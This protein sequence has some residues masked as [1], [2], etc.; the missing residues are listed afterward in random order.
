VTADRAA[1]GP[2]PTVSSRT[3]VPRLSSG[4]LVR[5]RDL[6][7]PGTRWPWAGVLLLAIVVSGVEA[8]G[9]VL[10]YTLMGLASDPTGAVDLPL[11]GDL[12][13]AFAETSTADLVAGVAVA[14]SVFFVVR[15]GLVVAQTYA[16]ARVAAA[17]SVWLST[18]LLDRYL[19]LPYSYHLRRN[20]SELIRNAN[21]SVTVVLEHILLP[22]VRIV[23]QGS[24][25]V[26]LC[27]VLISTAPVATLASAALLGPTTYLTMRWVRRRLLEYGSISQRERGRGLQL[28]QQSLHGF[29]D[30]TVLGRQAFFVD[31]FR[32]TRETIARTRY[33]RAVFGNLPRVLIE[34]VT[35]CLVAAAVAVTTVTN[36]GSGSLAVVGLF[37]YAALRIMP[38]L[39]EIT[40]HLNDVRYGRAALD[41]VH[42]DL[43]E[44]T[45]LEA[46]SGGTLTFR[47]E[48]RFESVTF[49]Y[50]G[51]ATPTLIGIDL[52]LPR[53]SSLGIVG[54]TGAGK[55]TL[56]DLLTGFL[57]PDD[58]V[59]LVDG[60]ALTGHE[61]AWRRFVG[62]VPQQVFLLDGTLRDNIAFGLPR[63]V[64]DDERV[65]SAVTAAQLETF[66]AG[67][68]E[69]LETRVGEH[70]T[71]VSG[72][73]RQ[74][75]AIAR[76][77]YRGPEMLVFDEGTSALDNLTE[78]ELTRAIAGLQGDHTIV[79]VAH[80]LSTVRDHD[81]IL[82]LDG[83]RTVGLGTYDTLLETNPTFQRLVRGAAATP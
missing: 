26:G 47:D 11:I 38:A 23:A 37:A 3:T 65:R 58:G 53:G 50:P 52:R 14:I 44:P 75:I 29:R 45:P 6:A 35:V 9:A 7:P 60:T 8:I 39:N 72:G 30:V 70:G 49:R 18:R 82:V 2:D 16:S 36:E 4:A 42:Q 28:L 46:S 32:Q 21:E 66:V 19:R 62:M 48:V 77:L 13:V 54:A 80:R 33:L 64:V 73:Q 51:A 76:A 71:R 56:V 25:V 12:R 69:G 43:D 55:S 20:S 68:P 15:G 79:T 17:S 61:R 31:A 59:I 67:L 83:G 5:Y 63:E 78:A 27:V 40:V 1:G 81:R 41:A 34:L 22:A 57:R 10:V 74:R 24:I